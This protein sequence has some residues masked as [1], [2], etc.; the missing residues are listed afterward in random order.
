[1]LS[2]LIPI[3][4]CATSELERLSDARAG[5]AIASSLEQQIAAARRVDDD[6]PPECGK[7]VQTGV[8]LGDDKDVAL[9]RSDQALGKA[10]SRAARCEQ[11]WNDFR[12]ARNK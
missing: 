9:L 4:G 12:E 1:M 8:K 5:T 11:W 10:N 7:R 6:N 3:S 2:A